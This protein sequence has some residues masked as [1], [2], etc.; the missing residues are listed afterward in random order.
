M[1]T[2]NRRNTFGMANLPRG[3]RVGALT[4]LVF[5]VSFSLCLAQENEAEREKNERV[6]DILV[7]LGARDGA[8]IAD[9]GSADGFY[10]LRIARA[11][12]PTGRAYAV[13]INAQ[14]LDRLRTR[15]Q[16]ESVTNIEIIVSEAADPKLPV[17]ALDAV[18]IRNAY[19]EMPEYR[20]ILDAV[21]N[22]LK[23]GGILIVIEGIHDKNRHLS[24]ELQVKEHELAPDI[25]EAEL[26]AAGFEILDRHDP[27]TT[28]RVAPPGGFWLLRARRR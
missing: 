16:K 25:V 21:A 11:V 13:D 3:C 6:A 24:R 2:I 18:L 28:F 22:S 17:G 15:M 12:A 26:R 7:A 8:Q 4:A 23:P 10:T 1:G 19:H 14:M 20:S 27:F 9:L 5:L